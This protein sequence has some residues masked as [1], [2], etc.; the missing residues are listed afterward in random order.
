MDNPDQSLDVQSLAFMEGL[1]EDYLRD[2][3]SVSESWR[4]YFASFEGNG[5][6]GAREFQLGPSFPA[7]SIFNGNGHGSNGASMAAADLQD[8]VDQLVRLFRVRGHM[9]AK[10]DPLGRPRPHFEELDPDYYG[11]TEADMEKRFSSKTIAGPDTLT[12]REIIEAMRETYCRSI[13]V[14]FM[15]INSTEKQDWLE[16]RME[17]TRNRLEMSA[18]MQRKI[19]QIL[20]DA[21]ILEDFIFK[22]FMGKKSFSLSGGET[23]MPLLYMALEKAGEND[24]NG[25]IIGMSHRGRMNV[26]INL[27]G[28]R[29]YEI[30]QEF[31]GTHPHYE[32]KRG[33]VKYH[34]GYGTKYQCD[35]GREM[36]LSLCF[37]PSHLEFVNP[38]VSGR[39]R[40]N[41]DRH[42]DNE[43][44]NGLGIMI[45]GDAAFIGEGIVQETL[46]LSQLKG[47]RTGGTL[48][49][50]VNNQL[51]FTTDPAD[52]RST[53]YAS[54][55]AKMLEVPI[56][57]VNGED[58]EAVAQVVNVAMDYRQRFQTDVVIDMYC[59][60]YWGHNE[61][62]EPMLTQPLMYKQIKAHPSVKDNY[63]EKLLKLNGITRAE[64]QAIAKERRSTLSEDLN[65]LKNDEKPEVESPHGTLAEVW[66]HY[67]GGLDSDLFKV[68]TRVPEPRLREL[69]AATI[70]LPE[71]F[72]PHDN[73][74]KH[75][76]K[77]QQMLDG[78]APLDWSAAEA[79]AYASLADEGI[80][81]RMSGQDCERGTFAHRYA[82]IHDQETGEMYRPLQ[83]VSTGQAP[84]R[85]YNSPLSEAGVLGFEFGYSLDYPD[86]LVIWEAQFGDFV[87][88]AQVII[89]QF[90]SS[91]EE[92]WEY[93]TGLV[94]LLPHGSEGMGSEHSSAR[95]ERFLTLCANDNMQ[96]VNVTTPAQIFHLLRRQ[97]KGIWRKPLIVMSPKSLFR[98][99]RVV[100]DWDDLSERRFQRVLPDI[101][102]DQD[103][104]VSRILLCSGKV[105]YELEAEREARGLSNVAIL[106]LEQIYPLPDA[107][108][109]KELKKYKAGTPL[110]WVQ[111]EPENFGAWRFLR[112]KWGN[113]FAGHPFSVVSRPASPS[114][115]SGSETVHKAEQKRLISF[116]ITGEQAE[117]AGS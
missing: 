73:V 12:L 49:I 51:G 59:F 17:S 14:Q 92:K 11:F 76:A 79:L 85:I 98:H 1:Y 45:H 87:N 108:L 107:S 70:R 71:G 3:Q 103:R 28:K 19:L 86:A 104:D 68:D 27:L 35:N 50:I 97:V 78:E 74:V 40:A 6:S 96:V 113:E 54:D 115:A 69:L 66:A 55:I 30:F 95:L 83:H 62:D 82:V 102:P 84:V 2:P 29:P 15:H 18:T 42:G 100:S 13:G 67:K 81:V 37:N 101:L 75:N 64:A 8:R 114:P 26:L 34:L 94:M 43:R 38:V 31:L 65:L 99:P 111:E 56:F 44:R 9:I 58:P 61:Q 72:H 25:V 24:M 36:H 106:R 80:P 46:N 33:D 57:H 90:I 116:A 32:N 89:D 105:Y 88:T 20:I 4:R 93:L 21:T 112:V 60:R 16:Q 5:D 7:R 23:L 63:Q 22:K 77:R 117:E 39:V 109:K 110:V 91:C 41:M 52:S 10:L 47:Y 53:T 48:H